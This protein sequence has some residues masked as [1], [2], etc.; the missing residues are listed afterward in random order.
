MAAGA[1]ILVVRAHRAEDVQDTRSRSKT[2]SGMLHM[3]GNNITVTR[4]QAAGLAGNYQLN[5]AL[6]HCAGLLV[7]MA[8]PG[9]CTMR[10]KAHKR[11]QLLCPPKC[12]DADAGKQLLEGAGVKVDES[13][14]GQR[15]LR[16]TSL[17]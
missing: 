1:L 5:L 2:A 9:H 11:E 4:L 6:Q 13:H 16:F 7:N 17:V 15:R 10:S 14:A 12:L 8:V 3:R